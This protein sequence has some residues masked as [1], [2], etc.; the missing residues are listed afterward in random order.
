M[1]NF[2][3]CFRLLRSDT[4]KNALWFRKFATDLYEPPYLEVSFY[5]TLTFQNENFF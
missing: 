2:H 5:L 1:N 3:K 4:V